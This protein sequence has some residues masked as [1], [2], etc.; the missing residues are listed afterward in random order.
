MYNNEVVIVASCFFCSQKL[1]K[2]ADDKVR[3]C[4]CSTVKIG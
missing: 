3:F 4:F 2:N 1:E